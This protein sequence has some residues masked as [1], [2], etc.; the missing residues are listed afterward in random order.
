M[1]N[2]VNKPN[3]TPIRACLLSIIPKRNSAHL[4]ISDVWE[5]MSKFLA[6]NKRLEVVY[7]FNNK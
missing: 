3:S 4:G 2:N 6:E 7:D 1:N 5:R